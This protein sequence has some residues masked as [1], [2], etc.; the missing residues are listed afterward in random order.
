M[1]AFLKRIILLKRIYFF[2]DSEKQFDKI[3]CLAEK[4]ETSLKKR[5]GRRISSLKGDIE[6]LRF[7]QNVGSEE[8]FKQS[9]KESILS[10]QKLLK[11]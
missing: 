11:S 3:I 8:T 1:P 10:I 4:T 7:G 6:C 9:I 5:L 2:D